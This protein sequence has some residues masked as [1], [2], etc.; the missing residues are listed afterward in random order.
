MKYSIYQ[1]TEAMD[2]WMMV[3]G[4]SRSLQKSNNLIYK[5]LG[6]DVRKRQYLEG[7]MDFHGTLSH[8]D[9]ADYR[10]HV[11]SNSMGSISYKEVDWV[12]YCKETMKKTTMWDDLKHMSDIELFN[13]MMFHWMDLKCPN[14]DLHY[15]QR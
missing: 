5:Y 7:Y 1:L 12:A 10:G 13:H 9:Y 15:P 14:A 8:C 3:G 4:G 11:L 6:I 2:F